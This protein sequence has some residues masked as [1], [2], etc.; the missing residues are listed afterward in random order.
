VGNDKQTH[1]ASHP[2]VAAKFQRDALI[3]GANVALL[4]VSHTSRLCCMWSEKEYHF[5]F[6][7][8]LPSP[9]SPLILREWILNISSIYFRKSHGNCL[10]SCHDQCFLLPPPNFSEPV[11]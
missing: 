1:A 11:L 10:L 9:G 5:K 8:F 7:I 6:C 2:V 4:W 3:N